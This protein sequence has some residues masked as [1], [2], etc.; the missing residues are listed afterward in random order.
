MGR[1]RCSACRQAGGGPS[2]PQYSSSAAM[3]PSSTRK[4]E[5]TWKETVRGASNTRTTVTSREPRASTRSISPS[6]RPGYS[7]LARMNSA[8]VKSSLV[9]GQRTVASGA[10]NAAISSG[11]WASVAAQ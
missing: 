1:P 2:S 3:R 11:R 10:K 7:Q 6:H 8:A 9:L 4:K 5:V